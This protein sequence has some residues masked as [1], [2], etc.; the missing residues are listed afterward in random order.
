MKPEGWKGTTL[1]GK[2]VTYTCHERAPQLADITARVEGK[3]QFHVQLD[4]PFPI[5][6]EQ[7]EPHFAEELKDD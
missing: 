6:H 2:Q 5:T 3:E 7:V 4:V 1:K